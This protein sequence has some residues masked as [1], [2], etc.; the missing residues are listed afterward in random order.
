MDIVLCKQCITIYDA[1]VCGMSHAD[2][3]SG[4]LGYMLYH[5]SYHT[6]LYW[7]NPVAE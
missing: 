7:Y 6:N 1:S 3:S 5:N 2:A 4:L